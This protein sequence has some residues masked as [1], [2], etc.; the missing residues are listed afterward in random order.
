MSRVIA[1]L[2][3]LLFAIGLGVAGMTQPAKILAFLDVTGAWDPSLLFVMGGAIGVMLPAWRILSR[4]GR[5]FGGAPIPLFEKAAVD[6][7]LVIGAAI[8]GVGWGLS[9]YCPGP[10]LVSLASLTLPPVIFVTGMILGMISLRFVRRP[11]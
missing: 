7:P 5:A 4:R 6:A 1:F 11:L 10:A 3:G 8:F 9:G 2:A